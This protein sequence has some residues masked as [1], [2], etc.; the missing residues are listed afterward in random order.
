MW[1]LKIRTT[2]L[3]NQTPCEHFVIHFG[4]SIHALSQSTLSQ[5]NSFPVFHTVPQALPAADT[6][7]SNTLDG[8]GLR[9]SAG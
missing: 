3:G 4:P 6:F 5:Y 1:V 7:I 9:G 8:D 2:A